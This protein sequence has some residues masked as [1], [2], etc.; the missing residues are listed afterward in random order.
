MQSPQ[1]GS[2][3]ALRT[4][5]FPKTALAP[6]LCWEL[7]WVLKGSRL[8]I[9]LE[10]KQWHGI[11]GVCLASFVYLTQLWWTEGVP[12]LPRKQGHS[13]SEQTVP[14]KHSPNLARGREAR[15]SR[16][17]PCFPNFSWSNSTLS[18][19]SLAVYQLSC[20]GF[21]HAFLKNQLN[22]FCLNLF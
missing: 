14:T 21:L 8:A 18:T 19:F 15:T 7:S 16:C 2:L 3:R 1:R 4:I 17:T 5:Y 10:S 13:S 9:C 6:A 22:Y 20:C 11:T 12:K